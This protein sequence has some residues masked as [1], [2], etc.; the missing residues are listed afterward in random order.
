MN[1]S[2]TTMNNHKFN[3]EEQG[4]KKTKKETGLVFFMGR[5]GVGFNFGTPLLLQLGS[6][7]CSSSLLR[8]T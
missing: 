6:T 8:M 7:L 1:V 4:K 5:G 2:F 3:P